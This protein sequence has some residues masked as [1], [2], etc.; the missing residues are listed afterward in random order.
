MYLCAILDCFTE[1]GATPLLPLS[2]GD[3]SEELIDKYNKWSERATK[4]IKATLAGI[5]LKPI[6]NKNYYESH[7]NPKPVDEKKKSLSAAAAA[8]ATTTA[9]AAAVP[10]PS[11]PL[12]A[13]VTSTTTSTVTATPTSASTTA[14]EHAEKNVPKEASG[15]TNQDQNVAINTKPKKAKFQKNVGKGKISKANAFQIQQK[16][17][18]E[19][20]KAPVVST[21]RTDT[22][23]IAVTRSASSCA[24]DNS[25]SA[26]CQSNEVSTVITVCTVR[27]VHTVRDVRTVCAEQFMYCYA[28]NFNNNRSLTQLLSSPLL[29][30]PL[31]FCPMNSIVLFKSIAHSSIAEGQAVNRVLQFKRSTEQ[32]KHREHHRAGR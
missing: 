32:G 11:T 5:E 18:K 9:A 21:V 30:T 25:D 31:L 26:C 17:V 8:A 2:L 29:F 15:T 19:E 27:D 24:S 14:P 22:S 13:T 7:I 20:A 12:V 1:L 3:D 6:V 16:L 4:K 23:T 28:T 10:F